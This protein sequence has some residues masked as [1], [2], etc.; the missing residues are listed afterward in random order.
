M[1]KEM[2]ASIQSLANAV[3]PVEYEDE[4]TGDDP[5]D[6]LLNLIDQPIPQGVALGESNGH[7]KISTKRFGLYYS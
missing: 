7:F 2:Q 1:M 5:R 4:G 6:V 3:Q